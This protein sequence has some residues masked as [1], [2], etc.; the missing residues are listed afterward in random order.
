MG[1]FWGE[2]RVY[3]VK[4]QSEHV[5]FLNDFIQ[6]RSSVCLY[7]CMFVCLFVCMVQIWQLKFNPLPSIQ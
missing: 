1:P 2:G 7:V 5:L 6:L 4:M 3:F